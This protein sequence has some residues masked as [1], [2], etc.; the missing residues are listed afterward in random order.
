MLV[1]NSRN[2]MKSI[3]QLIKDAERAAVRQRTLSRGGESQGWGHR[4]EGSA[5]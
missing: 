5:E 1:E 3:F 4:G 2:L